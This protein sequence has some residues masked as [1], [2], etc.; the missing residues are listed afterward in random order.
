MQIPYL[1]TT[2]QNCQVE[3]MLE[4]LRQRI[5]HNRQKGGRGC[6]GVVHYLVCV[7]AHLCNDITGD[8]CLSGVSMSDYPVCRQNNIPETA[9]QGDFVGFV[10]SLLAANS[11]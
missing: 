3:G 1:K 8:A 2:Q 7:C 4:K 10:V 9:D 5:S 11:D 6:G